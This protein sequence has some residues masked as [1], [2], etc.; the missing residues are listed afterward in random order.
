MN[1]LKLSGP[2]SD[3]QDAN[4]CNTVFPCTCHALIP[5]AVTDGAYCS[6]DI[7]WLPSDAKL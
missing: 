5:N 4:S 7:T 6:A 1:H 2:E 3:G